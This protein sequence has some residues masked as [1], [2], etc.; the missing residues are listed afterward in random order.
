MRSGNGEWEA[1]ATPHSLPLSLFPPLADAPAAPATA[2]AEAC[3]ETGGA[4]DR[5][6]SCEDADNDTADGES[7]KKKAAIEG[8]DGTPQPKA[9][10]AAAAEQT[11]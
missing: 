8:T 2:T 7:P 5:K 3:A 1:R 10:D 9:V 4:C 6:R 11:A